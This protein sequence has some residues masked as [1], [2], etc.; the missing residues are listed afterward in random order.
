MMI[1]EITMRVY[2]IPDE[3]IL[4]CDSQDVRIVKRHLGK[5]A[6]EFNA[7]FVIAKDGDYEAVW[8]TWKTFPH[9]EDEV[10]EIVSPYKGE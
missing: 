2:D 6:Y 1:K 9:M 8:G 3:A 7:F 10:V 5:D 4:I